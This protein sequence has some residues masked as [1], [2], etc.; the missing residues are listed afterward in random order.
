MGKF[1]FQ[2]MTDIRNQMLNPSAGK[3]LLIYSDLGLKEPKRGPG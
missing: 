3:G 2:N 1:G